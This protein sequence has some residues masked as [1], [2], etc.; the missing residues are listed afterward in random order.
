MAVPHPMPPIVLGWQTW[1]V[2]T[3]VLVLAVVAAALL[4]WP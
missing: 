4:I 3:I 2:V 1:A